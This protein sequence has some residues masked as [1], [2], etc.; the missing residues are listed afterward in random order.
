M[1]AQGHGNGDRQ[2]GQ[3]RAKWGGGISTFTH[4]AIP[5][6]WY[7][8]GSNGSGPGSDGTDGIWLPAGPTSGSE[9]RRS[10]SPLSCR[11]PDSA[12]D[13][14]EPRSVRSEI[15]DNPDDVR[16]IKSTSELVCAGPMLVR[17]SSVCLRL[18]S[19]CT[20]NCGLAGIDCRM[21]GI[22]WRLRTRIGHNIGLQAP[23]SI[24]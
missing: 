2:A 17:L 1:D 11:V 4:T 20:V 18:T 7:T 6:R 15:T 24:Q 19:A 12:I 23:S 5:H 9:D 14:C 16:R 22:L 13:S 8:S 3:G 21:A 10:R